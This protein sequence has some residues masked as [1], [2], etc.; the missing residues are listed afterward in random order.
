MLADSFS[1]GYQMAMTSNLR[2]SVA[3]G[4]DRAESVA[5]KSQVG[6]CLSGTTRWPNIF[7]SHPPLSRSPLP[8]CLPLPPHISFLI[9]ASHSQCSQSFQSVL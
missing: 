5:R 7:S 2:V 4:C 6:T 8:A 1:K 3:S 9:L